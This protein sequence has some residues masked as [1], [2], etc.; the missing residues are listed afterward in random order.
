MTGGIQK[1]QVWA[2][3]TYKTVFDSDMRPPRETLINLTNGN[4]FFDEYGGKQ[5]TLMGFHMT[6]EGPDNRST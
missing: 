2:W 3:V 6:A 1:V 5:R 4:S